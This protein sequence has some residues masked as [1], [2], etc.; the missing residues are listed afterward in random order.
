MKPATM[1]TKK[2][3]VRIRVYGHDVAIVCAC[4]LTLTQTTRAPI[5]PSCPRCGRVWR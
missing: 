2:T 5:A 4:G 1:P 3:A